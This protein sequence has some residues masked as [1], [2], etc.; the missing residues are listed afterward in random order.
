MVDWRALRIQAHKRLVEDEDE[1]ALAR[2]TT[3]EDDGVLEV[4]NPKIS[5]QLWDFD[6]HA[7]KS[8]RTNLAHLAGF[9]CSGIECQI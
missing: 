6:E 4:A 1:E 3:F 7:L 5:L 2:L 8:C 9:P